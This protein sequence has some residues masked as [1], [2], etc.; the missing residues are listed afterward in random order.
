MR[1]VDQFLPD[2]MALQLTS[3]MMEAVSTTETLASCYKTAR[4]NR[5]IAL[6]MEAVSTSETV[7]LYHTPLLISQK[8]VIFV[9]VGVT[10]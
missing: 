1:N 8:T 5:L 10:T 6:M 7:S 3:P 4:C 2:Y 9:L